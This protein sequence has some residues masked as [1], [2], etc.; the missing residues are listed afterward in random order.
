MMWGFRE[1]IAAG[2]GVP[3]HFRSSGRLRTSDINNWSR[4]KRSPEEVVVAQNSSFGKVAGVAR[5]TEF[6]H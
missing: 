5:D 4:R 6:G 1:A 3:P 2:D